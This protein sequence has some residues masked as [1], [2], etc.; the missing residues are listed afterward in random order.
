[1]KTTKKKDNG[2]LCEMIEMFVCLTKVTFFNYL[3][4]SRNTMSYTLYTV[5]FVLKNHRRN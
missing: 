4:V 3:Y 2:Q 5:K 1:M